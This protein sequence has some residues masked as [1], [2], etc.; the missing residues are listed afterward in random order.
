MAGH[1]SSILKV[2]ISQALSASLGQKIGN[3]EAQEDPWFGYSR[4]GEERERAED[5]DG[6]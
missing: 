3:A 4:K 6:Y 5:G 1:V 2:D